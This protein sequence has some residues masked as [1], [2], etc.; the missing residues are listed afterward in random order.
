MLCAHRTTTGRSPRPA[1]IRPCV[2]SALLALPVAFAALADSP[3]ENLARPPEPPPEPEPEWREAETTLPAFPAADS[4]V[5]LIS[6]AVGKGYRYFID[7]DSVSVDVDRV[8][9]YTVVIVYPSGASNILYEGIRCDTQQSKSYAYGTRDG[10]FREMA[11]SQWT[12]IKDGG[13]FAYRSV[14]ADRYLC[15]RDGWAMDA[16]VVLER[17]VSLDPRRFSAAP[18]GPEDSDR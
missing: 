14:L 9:R 18:K 3:V 10:S 4:L 7:V 1:R 5:P 8:T 6:A 15:D 11:S 16:D 17:I 13:A 12:G 2:L